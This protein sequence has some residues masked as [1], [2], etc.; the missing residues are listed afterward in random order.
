VPVHLSEIAYGRA[1]SYYQKHRE[2]NFY[3]RCFD[4]WYHLLKHPD[5][6][7]NGKSMYDP[8]T[9]I[10]SKITKELKLLSP[11][12]TMNYD[13]PS[14]NYEQRFQVGQLIIS[15]LISVGKNLKG[16]DKNIG[17]VIKVPKKLI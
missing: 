4:T 14:N 3:S 17:D 15:K 8:K 13:D 9:N 16:W 2:S 6:I 12:K 7:T 5:M 11:E 10:I 1:L